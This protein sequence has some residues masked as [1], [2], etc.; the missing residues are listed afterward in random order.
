LSGCDECRRGL[1]KLG[2]AGAATLV[3]PACGPSASEGA[4]D[5]GGTDGGAATDEGGG[6]DGGADADADDGG[7]GGDEA[8]CTPTCTTGA[9][10]LELPFTKYPKLQNV[11]G[12]A[13]VTATGYKDPVCGQALVIVAQTAAGTYVALSASCT[14]ACCTVAYNTTRTEFTCPCHGSVFS[15]AGKV[16]NGPARTALPQLQVCAD[17]C[18]VYV[19]L[20]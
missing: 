12:S 16:V 18:G 10:T 2:L 3:L 6:D 9:N 20:P 17:A 13:V 4:A 5:E 19:T 8:G 11:G 14:H 15:T 1:L 7:G